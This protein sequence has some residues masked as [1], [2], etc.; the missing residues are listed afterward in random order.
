MKSKAKVVSLPLSDGGRLLRVETELMR[1]TQSIEE[2]KVLVRH[3]PD[4]EVWSRAVIQRLDLFFEMHKLVGML[5]KP[6]ETKGKRHER[7]S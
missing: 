1:L 2:L 4:V 3:H 6:A 5:L 7:R